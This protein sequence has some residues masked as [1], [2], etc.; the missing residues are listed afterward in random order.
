VANAI[1][2]ESGGWFPLVV[3]IGLYVMMS[4]WKRGR[5]LLQDLLRSASLPMDLFLEDVKRRKPP[6]VPGT[7]VFMTSDTTGAPVVL[8]HHLKHNKVLH[9]QVILL[10]ILTADV[11]EVPVSERVHLEAL[12]EGFYRATA[13]FGFMQT[14]SVR[15][16][17]SRCE[18][19]GLR[20]R[21]GDTSFYLGREELIPTGNT[22]MA[23]WRKKLFVFMG[24]NARAATQFFGLP[25]NRVV[26]LGAQ[27]EF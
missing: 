15:E 13:H 1:K 16:I 19:F 21:P 17:L 2:V 22:P 23:R 7:A 27:I 24:R 20:V 26:E 12:G 10:S 6:R 11:P 5:T 3:A 4:T 8:L 14:P 9:E 25:P 18:P